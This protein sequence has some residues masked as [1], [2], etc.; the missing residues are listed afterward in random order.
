V[1]ELAETGDPVRTL[2]LGAVITCATFSPNGEYLAFGSTNGTVSVLSTESWELVW[3]EAL[4]DGRISSIAF[5]QD[6]QTL[7]S[8]VAG[9]PV[10][11]FLNART[12][13]QTKRIELNGGFG[14]IDHIVFSSD[15]EIL[16]CG[17][18]RSAE[19]DVRVNLIDVGTGADLGT[20]VQHAKSG[21]AIPIHL[22]FSPDGS[23]LV[24]SCGHLVVWDLDAEEEIQRLST[25]GFQC[26]DLG[27]I[28]FSPDGALLVAVGSD[29]KRVLQWDT[30]TWMV[31]YFGMD[32]SDTADTAVAFSPDGQFLAC[33]YKDYVL[34]SVEAKSLVWSQSSSRRGTTWVGF[35]P[36]SSLFAGV[37]FNSRFVNVWNVNELVG[38]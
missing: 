17:D 30:E 7:A 4:C 20:A 35:S 21:A 2:E 19:D 8:S 22:A 34:R 32:G 36:D 31:S 29:V 11:L 27:D 24:S 18:A 5:S 16:A 1:P 23:L 6:S 28:A 38:E 12:G 33:G 14:D 10:V 25:P 37:A 13:R 3:E 26:Y 15:G 9:E